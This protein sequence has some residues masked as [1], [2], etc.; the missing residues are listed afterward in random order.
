MSPFAE[1]EDTYGPIAKLPFAI[2]PFLCEEDQMPYATKEK[3]QQ[4]AKRR[5]YTPAQR[6]A[7]N[8]YERAYR[9][10]NRAK[11]AAYNRARYQ[12][13]THHIAELIKGKRWRENNVVTVMLA[14]A[15]SRAK[16][17]GV[18]FSLHKEDI[19]IPLYCPVLGVK[20][21]RAFDYRSESSPSLDRLIPSLGYTPDN[22]RVISNRAN[23]LKNNGTATEFRLIADYIERET[24][25]ESLL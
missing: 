23:T 11:L 1:R 12:R 5:I 10:R 3:K 2:G 19:C 9:L 6:A 18:T 20:L 22:V 14:K 4:H 8:L 24:S 15:K 25:N 21:R 7:R 16:K 13:P 17:A